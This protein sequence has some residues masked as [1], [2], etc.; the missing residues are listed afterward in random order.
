LTGGA[1]LASFRFRV[2]YGR[3]PL[4]A[5]FRGGMVFPFLRLHLG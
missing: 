3:Y 4:A 2:L 1:I 5:D